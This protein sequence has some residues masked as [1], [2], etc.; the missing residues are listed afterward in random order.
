MPAILE[1][2]VV[3]IDHIGVCVADIDA[4]AESFTR[5]LGTPVTEREHVA[6]QKVDVGW[7]TL[8]GQA[9]RIELLQS[10]GNSGLERFMAK[11]GNAMHHLAISVSDIHA[12][13]ARMKDAGVELIDREPRPGAQ[14]HLVAFLHPRAM[15]GILV[16]LV[17]V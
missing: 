16:E 9:T 14:G 6:G 8:P 7:L 4:A 17:Q 1:G 12:A 13:V 3:R 2:L 11:R 15:S 10:A 5:L